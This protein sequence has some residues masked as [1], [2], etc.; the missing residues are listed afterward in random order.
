MHIRA[1][2]DCIILGHH[3][4]KGVVLDLPPAEAKPALKEGDAE[5]VELPGAE[6]P[7]AAPAK[8]E[9]PAAAAAKAPAQATEG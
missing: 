5:V 9:K 4:R 7:E 3:V 2:R 1:T 6:A 8:G